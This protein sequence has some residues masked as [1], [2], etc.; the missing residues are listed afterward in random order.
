[1]SWRAKH[2]ATVA[3]SGVPLRVRGPA[4]RGTGGRRRACRRPRSAA[5]GRAVRSARP[6][7]L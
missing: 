2:A 4:P 3:R 7:G 6:G 5:A 1:M